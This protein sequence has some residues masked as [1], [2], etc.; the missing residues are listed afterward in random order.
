MVDT[1]TAKTG[2]PWL[3]S[4]IRIALFFALLYCVYLVATRA[5]AVWYFRRQTLEG[6]RQAIRWD[7]GNPRYPAVLAHALEFSAEESN[8]KEVVRLYERATRLAPHQAE[9]W[10]DL[11]G[12]YESA[13]RIDDARRAYERAAKLF[14]NSPDINWRLGNFYLRAGNVPEALGRIKEA[15]IGDPGMRGPAFDLA[16]RATGNGNLILAKMI[17]PDTDNLFAYLSYL[18]QAQ[19]VD[20]AVR[21]WNRILQL[22]L[23]FEPQAAFPYL[24]ALIRYERIDELG[25][26]WAELAKRNPAVIRLA[27]EDKD[28]IT[29]GG[30]EGEILNGGLGW[31][32]VPVEGVVVETD[33]Q[34][35]LDGTQALA[36]RFGGKQNLNY[37]QVYQ[38]VLARPDTTY[39]FGAYMRVQEV[40]TDSGPRFQVQDAYDPSKLS[41]MTES[42]IGTSGWQIEQLQFRTGSQTRLLVVRLIRLPSSKFDNKIAGTV[43]I[44]H[45]GLSAVQ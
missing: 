13:G 2:K 39:R 5:I 8:P 15:M 10:A 25:A 9:Y 30:F 1:K 45:I 14:P 42:R 37:G 24:D 21:V 18:L 35:F 12:A 34:V 43:W 23:Q 40:T 19:R 31:R 22:Q 32:V 7:P 3:A 38:Y 16:W 36:I 29:D 6:V 28:L 44:D 17:P 26:A 41:V 11:G 33:S 4:S 20:E 27:D